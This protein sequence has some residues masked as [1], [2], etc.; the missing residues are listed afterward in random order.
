MWWD[1]SQYQ[2]ESEKSF[3][4]ASSAASQ[5]KKRSKAKQ[6]IGRTVEEAVEGAN[7]MCRD[8]NRCRWHRGGRLKRKGDAV[9]KLQR[10][11]L[12]DAGVGQNCGTI[13]QDVDVVRL[14]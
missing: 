4:Q 13:V 10:D 5:H 6:R 3:C 7:A 2:I 14:L 9:S 1:E 8:S 11:D 12:Y